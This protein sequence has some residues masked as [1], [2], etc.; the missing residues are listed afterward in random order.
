MRRWWIW[1][2]GAAVLLV[3]AAIVVSFFLDEPLRR[4]IERQMNARLQGYT[5]HIGALDLHPLRFSVDLQDVAIAQEAHPDPPIIRIPKLHASVQW[6]ALLRA[7]VVA[8]VQV[9]RPA[10]HLNLPQLAQETRDD[11]P[12]RERGWQE[13]LQA[14]TPLQVNEVRVV[15]GEVTY[16]D[17]D[18]AR[19]LH[20]SH[21]NVRAENIRNIKSQA[22]EYPSNLHLEGVL[23]DSG[24]LTL[25]GQADF[26]AVPHAAV[27]AQLTLERVDLAHFQPVAR[28]YNLT[29]RKGVLSAAGDLEY[30]PSVRIVH[31]RQADVQRLQLDYVH[32]AQTAPVE[33][34]RAR[35]VK[36]VAQEASNAPGLLI[37]AD[38]V[39]VT[40]SQ[41]GFVNR[42]VTPAYRLFLA[43]AE[44]HLTNF[45]NQLTQGTAVAKVTGKFMGSGQTTVGASFRPETNGPDFALVAA[46]ENTDMR[47]L[48]ELLRAYGK[49]DVEK[50]FFSV[51]TE[52]RVQNR[53]VHGFV[54]PL[55]REL[56]VYDARQDADKNLFQQLYEAV[57]GGVSKLLENIPRREVATETD[58]SGPL[59]QPR[60]S[61][62]EV[63][64][65]L[66]QNA[67][68]KAILP[69]FE[70]QL[71]RAAR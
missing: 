62:W 43:D 66:I 58:I 51:F 17:N 2:V 55:F 6:R 10:I 41:I 53:A 50:G 37:R 23:F 27:K 40:K 29:L 19:P 32:T 46:I 70:R 11:V 69:G 5:V 45:S 9:E 24:K 52:M 31:L 4:S 64:V 68:F 47:A 60:A 20:L 48:N 3:G 1:L 54:K 61:T 28:R 7:R 42:A 38:R 56:D 8:D 33:K 22:G 21:L 39:S 65:G 30:A 25:D 35:Q 16:I 49:F 63:L 57:V 36:R 59:E 34:A 26:L 18:P 13:A 67:F 12:L 15:D 71:G 14:V 44:F